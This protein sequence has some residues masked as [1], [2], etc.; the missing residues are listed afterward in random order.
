MIHVEMRRLVIFSISIVVKG[1]KTIA[2]LRIE[3]AL[4]QLK[5]SNKPYSIYLKEKKRHKQFAYYRLFTLKWFLLP[6]K[7]VFWLIW[8]FIFLCLRGTTWS[9]YDFPGK[10]LFSFGSACSSGNQYATYS[11]SGSYVCAWKIN[12][13]KR[14]ELVW[15][16]CWMLNNRES[17]PKLTGIQVYT[18]C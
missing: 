10:F 9:I 6:V 18:H 16:S 1:G 15:V 14:G 13:N 2:F 7:G 3:T 8:L 5:H 17:E 4:G 12:I 11:P